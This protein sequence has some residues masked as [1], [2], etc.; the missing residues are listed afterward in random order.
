MAR[1]SDRKEFVE[2]GLPNERRHIRHLLTIQAMAGTS[3]TVLCRSGS[4]SPRSMP[5]NFRNGNTA[6]RRAMHSPFFFRA[7]PGPSGSRSRRSR[8]I[9]FGI[10]PTDSEIRSHNLAP[11]RRLSSEPPRS[12][13]PG[14]QS[15]GREERGEWPERN[16]WHPHTQQIDPMEPGFEHAADAHLVEG[17]AL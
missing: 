13:S 4:P 9:E 15:T 3:R 14:T 6:V 12:Q 8:G 7:A 17:I 5:L 11:K 16:R 1:E 2:V 10:L